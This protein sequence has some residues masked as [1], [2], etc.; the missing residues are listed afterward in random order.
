MVTKQTTK[1]GATV[2][3][4]KAPKAKTVTTP[5]ASV[6]TSLAAPATQPVATIAHGQPV[7]VALRNGPAVQTVR[8]T[9]K[10]YRT[11]AAHNLDWYATIGTLATRTVPATVAALLAAKVPSHFI[12][13]CMRRGYLVQV[14]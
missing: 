4:S 3:A 1:A 9:G 10:L 13:Y 5:Q 8:L 12:G 7:V 6:F 2:K 14:G 11:K